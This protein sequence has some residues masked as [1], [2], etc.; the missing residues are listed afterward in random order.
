MPAFL[1]HMVAADNIRKRID[2]PRIQNVI[3]AHA[4]AYYSG[5]QGGDYF[6]SYKYYSM[7]AGR[8]YKMF[9]YALHRARVQRFFAEGAAYIKERQS[10]VLK[11]FFY[12]YITHYCLDLYLHPLIIKLGPKAMSSHNTVEC[13]IDCMYARENGIDPWRF[14][15]AG[16]IRQTLVPTNEIDQFFSMIMQKLYYGFR[17]K[18]NA[19]HTAYAYFE[20]FHRML[21]EPGEKK[22]R[23]M[24][25]HDHFTV[26]K[27]ATLRYLPYEAIKDQY[28]YPS[29]FRVIDKAI[30]K[31]LVLIE[32]VD[33]YWND[34]CDQTV[35]ESAFWNVNFNGVAIV[36]REER[37]AFR[38]AYKKA[39]LKW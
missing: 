7:W 10:D 32:T 1:T 22:I 17:L 9:G 20:T 16:F 6:Y 15:K 26:L 24:K 33:R 18:P 28:D 3:S 38:R 30:Q 39:K 37:K 25:F 21:Q 14:D 31:S 12:G 8:T 5:V 19:Y 35:L 27:T 4:D 2:N 34:E 11:A 36:P 13:A 29:L 23:A